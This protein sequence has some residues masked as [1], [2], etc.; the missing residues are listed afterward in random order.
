MEK[1]P[2]VLRPRSEVTAL[3]PRAI[4]K[5]ACLYYLKDIRDRLSIP[6]SFS[7]RAVAYKKP[8][9]LK[10]LVYLVN[11]RLFKAKGFFLLPSL[12][13]NIKSPPLKSAANDVSGRGVRSFPY[14]NL[15]LRNVLRK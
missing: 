9:A 3:E 10:T 15:F 7:E 14:H 8:L 4:E 2:K 11:D 13:R 5:T 12:W 6:T 1:I